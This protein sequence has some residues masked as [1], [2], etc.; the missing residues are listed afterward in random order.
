MSKPFFRLLT[1]LSSRK[2][3]SQVTGAFARSKV[4]R[5]FIPRFAQTSGIRIE[6]A[7]KQLQDYKSLNDFFT[8]R[9]K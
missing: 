8:R 9:L 3:V 1:E 7:E 6:D 2:W 5:I 4:S